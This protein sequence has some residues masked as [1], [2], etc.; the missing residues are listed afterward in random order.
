MD[1]LI[2]R[3]RDRIVL[4]AA[5]F[6]AQAIRVFGSRARGEAAPDS[7]VDLLVEMEQGR[8]L[9][10]LIGLQQE[11]QL[12]LGVDVDVLTAASLSPYIRDAIERE[13]VPL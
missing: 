5:K 10:D 9:L 12:L 6:G 8:S 11:L 2:E 1:P 7:D 13:A 4:A 3:E